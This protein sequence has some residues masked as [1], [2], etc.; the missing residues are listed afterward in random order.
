MAELNQIDG[1]QSH[2]ANRLEEM[3]ETVSAVNFKT[4]PQSDEETAESSEVNKIFDEFMKRWQTDVLAGRSDEQLRTYVANMTPD[5]L[6]DW[7]LQEGVK[8]KLIGPRSS[9]KSPKVM[10][11][12]DIIDRKGM[13]T[14]NDKVQEIMQQR[15]KGMGSIKAKSKSKIKR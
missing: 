3:G 5:A 6:K 1:L 11:V 9:P 8:W 2:Y 12:N 7:F 13:T 14:L 4:P 15:L 10:A